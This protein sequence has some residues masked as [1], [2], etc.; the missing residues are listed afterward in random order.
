M[1]VPASPKIY[2][3][4]HGDRLS[5]IIHNKGLFCDGVMTNHQNAGTSIGM[6]NI[7]ERRLTWQ[8]PCHPGTSVGDYVPFYFCPRSIMLYV[9]HR[10]SIDLDSESELDYNGGQNAVVHLE[11]DLWTVVNW[12]NVDERRWA[13]STGNAAA[14]G[15]E[16]YD[17]LDQ[18]SEI[19][20]SAVQARYW[21]EVREAKQAEFLVHGF[22]P[23]RLVSRIG[24]I[25]SQ[26]G[27]RVTEIIK[28]ADHKPKIDVIRDWYY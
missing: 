10:K 19:D 4:V 9:I 3:I 13:F 2:H 14:G 15:S 28:D 26:I 11:A 27:Q 21:S 1:P 17:D 20:W 18:L 8:V 25:S 7:K 23:W 12:A 6:D 24:V 22:F 16:F 5:P